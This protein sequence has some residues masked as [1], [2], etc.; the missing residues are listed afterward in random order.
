[1]RDIHTDKWQRK[2][3]KKK[4]KEKKKEVVLVPSLVFSSLFISSPKNN[5]QTIKFDRD[6]H[7]KSRQ[8][9]RKSTQNKV[10]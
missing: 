8:N 3:K 9:Q 7:Y 6:E 10:R 5:S 4:K 1:L 2:K